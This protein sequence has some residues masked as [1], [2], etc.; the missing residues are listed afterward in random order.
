MHLTYGSIRGFLGVLLIA[1]ASGCSM[2]GVV[3]NNADTIVYWIVDD[4]LDFNPDQRSQFNLGLRRVHVWHR[5]I[6]L[7]KYA[8]LCSETAA[9]VEAG[10][11]PQDLDWLEGSMKKRYDALVSF[12]AGELAA[13]LATMEPEQMD[14]A[15]LKFSKMNVK[16]SKEHLSGTLEE[17]EKRRVSEE[18]EKIEDWVGAL[19]PEQ[20]KQVVAELKAMPQMNDHRYVH[21]LARQK[22]L[23]ELLV[24]NLPK[25]KL[26]A[27]LRD[28]MINWESGRT[29][30][31]ERL[32]AR[33]QQ[34]NRQLTL[35]IVDMLIPQQ[36]QHLVH[37]LRDYAEQFQKLHN[38]QG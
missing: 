5:K 6:E 4:Y 35:D 1:L 18:L 27:A 15:D 25:D 17:R 28:W 29:A 11:K 23:R 38:Q 16:F 12:S 3:Y 24:A 9:R 26:E 33:W 34:Q 7:P 21:R 10:L 22:A 19:S 31:H 32:W 20:E 36:R 2:I 8:A 14:I 30:E 13:V 37:K